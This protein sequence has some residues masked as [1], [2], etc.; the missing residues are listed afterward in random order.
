[1]HIVKFARTAP[2][3]VVCR[4]EPFAAMRLVAAEHSG[5]KG[6]APLKDSGLRKYRHEGCLFGQ[7][8]WY[9]WKEYHN[10]DV[11]RRFRAFSANPP[12]SR[13]QRQV[14]PHLFWRK[15]A[16]SRQGGSPSRAGQHRTAANGSRIGPMFPHIA[17]PM[18]RFFLKQAL[19]PAAMGS[20]L[21]S[22]GTSVRR[23]ARLHPA[24]DCMRNAFHF[25]QHQKRRSRINGLIFIHKY[26]ML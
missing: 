4:F 2:F 10:G 18:R 25:P 22:L 8:H 3:S 5:G 14:R 16:G 17:A 26:V 24:L 9:R 19:F 23:V 21:R 15:A 1:M 11:S 13:A 6:A 20:Y 12:K 7:L